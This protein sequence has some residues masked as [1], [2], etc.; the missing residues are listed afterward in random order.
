MADDALAFPGQ[1]A[2]Y[3]GMSRDLSRT[4][5]AAWAMYD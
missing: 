3:L 1:G 4:D 5:Q 2:Q